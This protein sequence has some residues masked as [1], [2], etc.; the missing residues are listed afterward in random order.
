[1]SYLTLKQRPLEET[2]TFSIRVPKR[3]VENFD[4]IS[5]DTGFS[6]NSMIIDSME[7]YITKVKKDRE[8][9]MKS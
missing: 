2:V 6:R 9:Y 3:I 4:L 8:K 5:S 7:K 1:M